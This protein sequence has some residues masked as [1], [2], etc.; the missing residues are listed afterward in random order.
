MQKFSETVYKRP[1][2]VAVKKSIKLALKKVK[3]ADSA[4]E[5]AEAL[6]QNAE[7]MQNA[8]TAYVTASIR[9]TMDTTDPF[10]DGEMQY[11]NKA[12]PSLMPL[13]KKLND[14]V[15]ASP[16]VEGLKELFGVQIINLYRADSLVQSSRIVP[17]LISEGKVCTE[18]VMCYPPGIPIL[19]PGE[20]VTQEIIDYILY[21]KAKGCSM[22][23]PEDLD[24]E[25]LNV[26][27]E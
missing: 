10:Y 20:L 12:L 17:C 18:Y 13:S 4:A 8:E 16:H 15:L 2:F 25:R 21:A 22:T 7:T 5:V 6:K 27:K 24:I 3:K 14:A 19:A 1:D 26:L 11:Y 23:G 9:N